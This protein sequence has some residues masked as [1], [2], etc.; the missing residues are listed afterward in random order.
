MD[1]FTPDKW[2]FPQVRTTGHPYFDLDSD[3]CFT[4]NYGGNISNTGTKNGFIRLLKWDKQS[5]LKGWNI[6]GRD[7]RPAYIAAT[8]HSLGVT[9]N[10]ILIF[11]TAAQVEPLRMIGIRSVYAQQHRTP[12]WVI[13]KK[14]LLEGRDIV[15][16]DYIEL[17]FDTSDVMCN[18]MTMMMKLRFMGN[19]WVPWTSLSLSTI[20]INLSLVEV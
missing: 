20:E 11:E 8:A 19:T 10:H 6:L 9:R 12:V 13:R 1:A 15:T 3:E 7:G 5:E 4:I 18:T 17:N 16:A 2:L 14:D